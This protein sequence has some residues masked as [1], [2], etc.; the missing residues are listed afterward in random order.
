MAFELRNEPRPVPSGMPGK[1]VLFHLDIIF[2]SFIIAPIPF[3]LVPNC[4]P[5]VNICS[6]VAKSYLFYDHMDCS[7]PCFSVHGIS[8]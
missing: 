3:F 4:I 2:L 7:P 5:I 1:G 6:L 8:M